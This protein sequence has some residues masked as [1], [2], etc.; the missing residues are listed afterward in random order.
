MEGATG[1][2]MTLVD[3]STVCTQSTGMTLTFDKSTGNI[4]V[5]GQQRV[6]PRTGGGGACAPA[7]ATRP[8]AAVQPP[9]GASPSPRP[10]APTR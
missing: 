4:K 6:R 1:R 2:P 8:R 7:A 5:D 9:A 10:P 3:R